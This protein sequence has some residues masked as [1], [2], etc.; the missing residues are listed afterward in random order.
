MLPY[1]EGRAPSIHPA[2]YSVGF[3]GTGADAWFA[4]DYK[5]ARNGPPFGDGKWRLFDIRSDPTEATDLSVAQPE[6][7][8]KMLA[9]YD[10]YLRVNGV[11]KPPADYN[12]L[13]QL[14]KNNWPV[15]LRQ[16]IGL[17]AAAAV[18]LVALLLAAAFGVR[19]G[20]RRRH[21]I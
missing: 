9:G 19:L 2:N 10:E 6:L 20:L 1:L 14:L 12:P 13:S 18:L 7:M 15:L 5:I 17:L 16:M 11:I 8:Q 4:A 21:A 3:E